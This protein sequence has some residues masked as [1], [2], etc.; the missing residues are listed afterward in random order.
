MF[1]LN[2]CL[3]SAQPKAKR[4]MQRMKGYSP[5]E[6]ATARAAKEQM[7]LQ[8]KRAESLIRRQEALELNQLS[9]LFGLRV[10]ERIVKK[11][12]KENRQLRKELRKQQQ[13]QALLTA[14]KDFNLKEALTNIVERHPDDVVAALYD[15]RKMRQKNAPKTRGRRQPGIFPSVCHCLL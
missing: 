2:P 6:R 10:K 8:Q 4:L 13:K 11:N 1:I 12:S 15:M 5:S 9:D 3:L 7:S 14:S